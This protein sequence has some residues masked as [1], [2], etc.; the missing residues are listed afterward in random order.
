VS[1]SQ[2]PIVVGL[3][4]LL[5]DCFA[6][7]RKPG[8]APANVAF[9]ACQLGCE[10]IVCSRV[11]QDSL[12][13][14]LVRFLA[15]QGLKTDGIQRDPAHPT[16]TVTV[17]ASRPDHP[18]YA[19]HENVAWDHIEF[20]EGAAELARS[21][22]AV[23]FGTLA[24]R[25]DASRSAI[26]RFLSSVAPH[27]LVVYDVNL[28]QHFH[29]RAW[30]EAS[31]DRSQ[32]VKL[33]AD[34]VHALD[35]LLGWNSSDERSFA[36]KVQKTHDVAVVCITQAERG[37]LLAAG[38]DWVQSPGVRVELADAVGAGDAFTAA[39]ILGQ[40]RGWPPAAQAS[41]ANSVGAMVASRPGAMPVL[42]DEFARLLEAY[43]G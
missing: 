10:G 27:C 33:N 25:C 26:R 43:P 5:W 35:R 6:D 18:R 12:G 36:R 22:S 11:G 23:C 7:G 28:R 38:D 1:D 34:E 31:L 13:D 32:V 29:D 20:G 24:Q 19:I 8:G 2:R 4:E 17:D 37:C 21:A 40:L 30:I 39:L 14:E 41:F 16:G 42:R 15:S 9:Q 3:G